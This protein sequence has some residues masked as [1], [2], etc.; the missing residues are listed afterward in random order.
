M[1]GFLERL[2]D[3]VPKMVGLPASGS[4]T[5]RNRGGTMLTGRPKAAAA[6]H[7]GGFAGGL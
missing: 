2:A 3:K 6:A 4:A 1:D 7:D 5:C